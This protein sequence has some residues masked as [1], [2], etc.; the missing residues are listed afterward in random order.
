MIPLFNRKQADDHF[1][2]NSVIYNFI[3]AKT[4]EF[5]KDISFN[6][7]IIFIMYIVLNKI[8]IF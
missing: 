4:I 1:T 6:V 3:F 7:I 8:T 5:V 2:L